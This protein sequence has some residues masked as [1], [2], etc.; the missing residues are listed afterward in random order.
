MNTKS[1]TK[2]RSSSNERSLYKDLSDIVR[3][4]SLYDENDP[5]EELKRV[6]KT[7]IPQSSIVSNTVQQL[8]ID[9]DIEGLM[10][11]SDKSPYYLDMIAVTFEELF[12]IYFI[13]N[14]SQMTPYDKILKDALTFFYNYTP[15]EYSEKW[16]DARLY[17]LNYKNVPFEVKK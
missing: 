2:E 3:K 14:Q 15:T 7:K 6:S 5:S 11:L 17:N 13:E 8:I 16:F 12:R 4:Y 10:N 1:S 9:H